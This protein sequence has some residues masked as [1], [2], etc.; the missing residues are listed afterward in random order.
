MSYFVNLCT[1]MK[2]LGLLHVHEEICD[3]NAVRHGISGKGRARAFKLQV[4]VGSALRVK[5]LKQAE[6]IQ[7]KLN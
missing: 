5:L 3:A 2:V 7:S 4:F 1:L 6:I